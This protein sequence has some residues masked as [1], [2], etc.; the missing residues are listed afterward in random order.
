M[1]P[2]SYH[3]RVDTGFGFARGRRIACDDVD[4]PEIT[5]LR[6]RAGAAVL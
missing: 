3:S 2:V 5:E 4:M 6:R 1:R